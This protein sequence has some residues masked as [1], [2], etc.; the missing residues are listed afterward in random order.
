MMSGEVGP[1]IVLR[2][3][4][5]MAGDL[6]P[7]LLNATGPA[8]PSSLLRILVPTCRLIVLLSTCVK[9][10]VAV[11]RLNCWYPVLNTTTESIVVGVDLDSM[12]DNGREVLTV[13]GTSI[14]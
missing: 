14:V 6:S 10:P 7:F 2:P 1:F 4:T 12:M 8:I 5:E 3:R 11:V 13:N 9:E